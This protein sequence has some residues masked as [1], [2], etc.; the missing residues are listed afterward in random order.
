[1]TFSPLSLTEILNS[2]NDVEREV[3]KQIRPLMH[4]RN[5]LKYGYYPFFLESRESFSQKL[6]AAINLTIENDLPST[7][8]IDYSSIYKHNTTGL[9]SDFL[10]PRKTSVVPLS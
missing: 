10:L 9:L 4:F 8:A 1:M 2:H 6:M 3:T 7:Q 5:Y